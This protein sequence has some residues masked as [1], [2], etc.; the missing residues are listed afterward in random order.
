MN[1]NQIFPEYVSVSDLQRNYA[2][3]LAKMKK[4]SQPVFILKKNKLEAVIINPLFYAQLIRQNQDTEEKMALK[5][6][7]IY[8]K[9]KKAKKLKKLSKAADL[10]V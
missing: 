7:G 2:D 8:Q 10:F 6:I 9:E 1:N 5:A 3:V 4:C